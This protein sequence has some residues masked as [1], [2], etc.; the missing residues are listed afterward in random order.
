MTINY[1]SGAPQGWPSFRFQFYSA[2][3]SGF[4][5][6]PLLD[7]A[8]LETQI[9]NALTAQGPSFPARTVAQANANPQARVWFAIRCVLER[10]NCGALTPALV[11]EPTLAFQLAAFFDPDAPSRPI[12]IGLPVD[13]TPAGLRKFD[14]NTAFV[15]SDVLCGQVTKMSSVSFLD[16]VLSIL[17]F[18]LH[19]DLPTGDMKPCAGGMVCSFSIP[20]ITIVALIL[21]IIFVKLLDMI[22]FWMPFFQ[23][24]LPLPNFSAKES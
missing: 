14:K 15:M 19:K 20:I 2:T 6:A 23:I 24:C 17:P 8:T 18:P 3:I 16:L 5:S 11:S 9:G 13:T 1:N 12:R 10:P 22:F 21:L 7:R 4:E